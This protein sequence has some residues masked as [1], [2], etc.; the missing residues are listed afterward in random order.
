MKS[1][2]GGFYRHMQQLLSECDEADE[3][4]KDFVK[5]R[6]KRGIE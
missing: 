2:Q 5:H 1:F 6:D 4:K 3:N